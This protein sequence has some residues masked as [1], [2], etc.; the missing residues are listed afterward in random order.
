MTEIYD[1][2][3]SMPGD[4]ALWTKLVECL[5]SSFLPARAVRRRRRRVS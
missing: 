3:V 4:D 2:V 5:E 1:E